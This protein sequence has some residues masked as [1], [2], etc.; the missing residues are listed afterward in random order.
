MAVILYI[1]DEITYRT[2]MSGELEKAGHSVIMADNGADAAK[3]IETW[4]STLPDLI[5]TDHK[6]PG[7]SG[8]E[9]VKILRGRPAFKDIPI[10]VL[11]AVIGQVKSL[12]Q[13]QKVTVID[14]LMRIPDIL[15]AINKIA[16]SVPKKAEAPP[17]PLEIKRN[18]Y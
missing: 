3:M 2:C 18:F 16:E 15:A 8:Y 4:K 17:P 13:E 11:S 6:M 1:E 14:K 9:L 5:I 10:I 7:M 12:E